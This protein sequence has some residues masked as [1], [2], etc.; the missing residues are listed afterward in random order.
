MMGGLQKVIESGIFSFFPL[1]AFCSQMSRLSGFF[2]KLLK[3]RASQSGY[4]Y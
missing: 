1:T 4:S 2:K 3:C